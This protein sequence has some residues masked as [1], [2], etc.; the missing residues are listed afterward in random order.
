M[1]ISTLFSGSYLKAADLAGQVRRVTI[2]GCAPEQVGQSE[3]KPVLK[4]RGVPKGLVLNK[5]NGMLIAASYGT[6]TLNWAGRE[7]ELYPENVLF[8]GQV[9]PAIR[10]RVPYGSVQAAPSAAGVAF[11]A[12]PPPVPPA[13]PPAAAPTAPP[14]A[15]QG[16]PAPVLQP[17]QAALP[18]DVEI[19]W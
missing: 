3:V 6:E 10:V 4:F 7:L 15:P 5:T 1:D 16:Q 18:L 19:N 8:Q 11:P 12:A 17:E 14:Q 9:V 13:T 2:D